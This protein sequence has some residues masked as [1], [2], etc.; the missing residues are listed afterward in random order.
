M[1]NGNTDNANVMMGVIL[2]GI[3]TFALGVVLG[4]GK[5]TRNIEHAAVKLGHATYE[6]NQ[7]GQPKFTWNDSCK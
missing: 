7:Y 4:V 3:I 2:L 5:G 1:E 6:G